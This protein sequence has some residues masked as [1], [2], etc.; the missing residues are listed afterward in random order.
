MILQGPPHD[1]T[2]INTTIPQLQILIGYDITK[3]DTGMTKSHI[4]NL[5]TDISKI[6]KFFVMYSL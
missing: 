3:H 2:A 1:H 6:Q 4:M 5:I